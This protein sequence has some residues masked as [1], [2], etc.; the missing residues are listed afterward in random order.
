V[1]IDHGYID[2]HAVA[3]GYI[4]HTLSLEVREAFERHLVDCQECADR[5]LLA[6]MFQARLQNGAAASIETTTG[7]T[8]ETAPEVSQAS[9]E[10]PQRPLLGGG[11]LM[12]PDA[13]PDA[14]ERRGPLRGSTGNY[15]GEAVGET[16][17]PPALV[18]RLRPLQLLSIL[19]ISV[20]LLAAIPILV[21]WIFEGRS[22]R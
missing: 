6:E 1:E 14:R 21:W 10:V 18:V 3:E 13:L 2:G 9:H 22:T 19:L 8:S 5:V 20:F 16:E 17:E 11:A 15:V 12:G 4:G 7:T